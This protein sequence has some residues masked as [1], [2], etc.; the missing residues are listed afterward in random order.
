MGANYLT[1]QVATTWH[2]NERAASS[3]SDDSAHQ[4]TNSSTTRVYKPPNRP[5]ST[6]MA[7]DDNDPQ[8]EHLPRPTTTTK[9]HNG[10]PRPP[11]PTTTHNDR[12][13]PSPLT[14]DTER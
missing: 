12:Y 8:T 4:R 14:N 7:Y 9:A 1:W 10:S 2:V 6:A 5:Q 3:D 13:R 11:R